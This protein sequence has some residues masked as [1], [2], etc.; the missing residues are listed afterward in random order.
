MNTQTDAPVLVQTEESV[1]MPAWHHVH[2]RRR[3]SLQQHGADGLSD[4]S[5]HHHDLSWVDDEEVV[6]VSR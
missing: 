3:V 2:E 6:F 4:F 1:A 5:V